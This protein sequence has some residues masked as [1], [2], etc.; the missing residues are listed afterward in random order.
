MIP[1]GNFCLC[2]GMNNNGN[3]KYVVK[4]KVIFLILKISLNVNRLF[5]TKLIKWGVYK[6][7]RSKL[8][9]KSSTKLGEGN[10]STVL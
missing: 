9:D 1:D 2:K 7:C 5:K 4:Y 3:V 8:H 6:I 10:G